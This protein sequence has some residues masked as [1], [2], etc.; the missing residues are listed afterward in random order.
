MANATPYTQFANLVYLEP[1][2]SGYSYDVIAGRA[3]DAADCAPSI[4]NEYVDAADFLLGA[5][6]FLD[7]HPQLHGPVYWVGES[8]A[9]VRVT[10][11]LAYLRGRWDLA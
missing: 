2:Q 10:W 8:Y 11:V 7:A 9:G 3:P 6:A 5:L 1:R 4:F